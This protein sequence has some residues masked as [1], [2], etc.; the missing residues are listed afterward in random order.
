MRKTSRNTATTVTAGLVAAVLAAAAPGEVHA[1]SIPGLIVSTPEESGTPAPSTSPSPGAGGSIPRFYMPPPVQPAPAKPAQPERASNQPPRRP[2][3]T[4]AK[5]RAPAPPK[6]A[7]TSIVLLVNDDPITEYE[8][9]QRAR[10]MAL[11][12]DLRNQVQSRFQALIKQPSTNTRLRAILQKTIEENP[13]KSRDHILKI[14]ESRKKAFALSLQQQAMAAARSSLTSQFRQKATDELVEERLKIHEAKRLKI[15]VDNKQLDTAIQQLASRNK[16]D[17]KQFE[18]QITN[19][20]VDFATMR[21]RIRAQ[22]SWN[23]VIQARFSRLISINQS[24]IDE[25]LAGQPD[26]NQKIDMRLHRIT[27]SLPADLNQAS[28]AKRLGQAEGLQRRFTGCSSTRQLA[29]TIPGARY[30]DL[31]QKSADTIPEPTRSLLLNATDGQMIPPTTTERGIELYAVCSRTA[32]KGSLKAQAEVR[33]ELRQKEF[34]LLGRR[35]LMDLKRD[36]HIEK[37]G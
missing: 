36:A 21:E 33:A 18:A 27:L 20:G 15:A 28:H 34:E 23:N 8:I 19:M 4:A 11:R 6:R 26:T 5:P 7:S 30:E 25:V 35:H 32:P 29:S 24:E 13:G 31:G 14:F 17:R 3:S 2:R 37:R 1:Q 9:E 22:L 12:G 10:L 16:M